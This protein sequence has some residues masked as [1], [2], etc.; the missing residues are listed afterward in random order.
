MSDA[1][2]YENRYPEWQRWLNQF[3][4]NWIFAF[5]VAMTIRHFCLE[6]FRIPTASMEPMLYGD[7]G[8]LKGDHVVVDKLTPRFTGYSR[9]D[10]TVFQFPRP[11]L[12]AGDDARPALSATGERL[13]DPLFRPLFC[14]NFVK[15]T[16]AVPGDVFYFSGGN[17]HLKQPDGTFQVARKPARIQEALWQDIYVQGEQAGY[18]PWATSGTSAVS[19]QGDGLSVT[20]G[21]QPVT[22]VQPLTNLYVKPGKVHVTHL[23]KQDDGEI[24]EV[25]MT[26]P[27]FTVRGQQ[28]NLWDFDSW[29]VERLTARDLDAGHGQILNDVMDEW[30]G[31][32]Q[33]LVTAKTLVGEATFRFQQGTVHAYDLTL[34]PDGWQVLGDGAVL[35][36]G[37]QTVIGHDLRFGLLDSQVLFNL[38]GLE[39]VRV[40]VADNDPSVQRTR[41]SLLSQGGGK[42][43]LGKVSLRR[44]LHYCA[45]GFLRNDALAWLQHDR[46]KR[47]PNPIDAA[48]AAESQRLIE[49]VRR[50]MRG[51]QELTGRQA[52]ERWGFNAE[53]AIT[54]PSGCYLLMGDNSPFSWDGRYWGWV[55]E[56]NLR[57]RALAV[58]FPPQRWRIV[59]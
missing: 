49:L 41:L 10:V 12:E 44:D 45:K 3:C 9:W 13:D 40:T 52:K 51:D 42:V 25:A 58:M 6:A 8:L 5:L 32:L 20:L 35:G 43:D 14:R 16:L 38:D 53:T 11:E 4:E 30:E 15:R 7:P 50:Q 23:P 24:V 17:L 47:G 22:F 36:S 2:T 29:Q 46:D 56:E 18:L 27:L 34:K 59:R 55:P 21:D 33:L 1:S 54:V 37:S 28:G 39:L 48:K 26:S 19:G 57:G 31:D